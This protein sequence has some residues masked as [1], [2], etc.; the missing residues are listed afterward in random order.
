MFTGIVE[1]VGKIV[2]IHQS[3][4]NRRIT[5]QAENT[6]RELSPGASVAVSGVC[7]TALDIK[8]T[9][10]C[11]DLAPETWV[12]TSFSRIH[13]NA[14]VNLELPMKADGR[15]GGHIVQ[16]HV[17]GVGKLISFEQIE[18]S[19]NWWLDIEV[20]PEIAKYTVYKGSLS[21]EG[22]S[23]TVAKIEGNRCAVAIIPHTVEMT[24]LGS[25]QPGDPVNLEADLIAK[26]VEKMMHAEAAAGSLTIDSLVE[27]GF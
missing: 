5:I 18:D 7:L 25:L 19:G 24:N 12:R 6:P 21:I 3:G 9:T 1:E 11:A 27:Q 14:L 8:P 23:L 22:I 20:P 15:F 4:Q 17:D 26:Y 10:F 2:S 16:G 13:Q